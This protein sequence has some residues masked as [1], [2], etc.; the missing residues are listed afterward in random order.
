MLHRSM[1]T[2]LR[3]LWLLLVLVA[4]LPAA[5]ASLRSAPLVHAA[6]NSPLIQWDSTMVIAGQNNGN[7]EGPVGEHAR[8]H[9]SNFTSFANQ[10]LS[11]G[12]VSG[13]SSSDPT[14]CSQKLVPVGIATP[15]ASG[16]FD[17]G[18]DWP[19]LANTGP[20]SICA[21]KSADGTPTSNTDSGPFT[22][23][24]DKP[25]SIAVS[26]TSVQAGGTI[27]VSGAHWVPARN[28]IA[29]YVGQCANCD[30]QVYVSQTVSS[31]SNGAFSV[32]L[33]IPTTVGATTAVVGAG[34][35][36]GLLTV[37]NQ[38]SP[39]VAI[40][41]PAPTAT[42]VPSPTASSA[43]TT[44]TQGNQGGQGGQGQQSGV[45]FG[46]IIGLV[47]AIVL[48]LAL[49]VAVVVYL[50]VKRGQGPP[51]GPGGPGG[52]GS[53]FGSGFDRRG[54]GAGMGYDPTGYRTP[55]GYGSQGTGPMAPVPANP[56]L[57]N[58]DW[59]PP[60]TSEYP[61]QG[62]A[63]PDDAPANPGYPRPDDPYR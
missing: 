24:S 5:L 61:G 14:L 32:T 50:L 13:D 30:G 3:S 40:A 57:W 28:D 48:L 53:G 29:V 31:S 58:D 54:V 7:P 8:V 4:L 18:F 11:L 26:S 33:T 19:T 63:Y 49:I 16:A 1:R 41:S 35:T 44:A 17:T 51:D 6:G 59:D 42:A 39:Q 43:A 38:D 20:W 2:A 62:S 23:L 46:V 45:N 27:T 55:G 12:L 37:S 25:V 22:V 52:P 10:Q 15:D 56:N 9:G 21:I 36:N 34:T 47:V 60:R